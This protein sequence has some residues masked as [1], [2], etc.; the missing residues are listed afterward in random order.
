MTKTLLSSGLVSGAVAGFVMAL[1]QFW[2]IQPLIVQAERYE[3]GEL[4]LKVTEAS[5]AE[6]TVIAAK[7]P[8]AVGYAH[9][10]MGAGNGLDVS[11]NFQTVLFLVLT[12]GGFG[13]VAS[14]AVAAL[15]A[16]GRTEH[17]SWPGIA[18][19][20]FAAFCLA[21]ALG[22]PPELPGMQ[23]ADLEARQFWWISTAFATSAGAGLILV[24]RKPQIF[25]AALVIGL[26]P[27]VVGAPVLDEHLAAVV[28]PEL[29]ALF[30]ARVIGT[31]LVG[32]VVLGMILAR[33]SGLSAVRENLLGGH[34][35]TARPDLDRPGERDLCANNVRTWA[36]LKEH[37]CRQS[38]TRLPDGR[39]AS[40]AANGGLS[41]CL[42]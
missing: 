28:P 8:A 33:M 11:R 2:L 13:L 41:Q 12:W 34:A 9:P 29:S 30:S 38:S 32:W 24:W 20:G 15:S 31:N 40:I 17:V 26:S 27:H 19:T 14:A 7:E 10:D 3:T 39:P 22:L 37:G 6:A 4:V 18:L 5:P 25:I 21:P 16:I 1:L 42:P 35:T 36:S 23:A